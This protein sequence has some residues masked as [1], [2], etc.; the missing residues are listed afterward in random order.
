MM[1][2]VEVA[3]PGLVQHAVGG[4]VAQRGGGVVH[5]HRLRAAGAGVRHRGRHHG[6]D[7]HV[8]RDI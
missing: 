8:G 7:D 5:V 6:V 1:V 3:A 4:R 2:L